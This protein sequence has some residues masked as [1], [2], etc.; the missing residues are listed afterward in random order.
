MNSWQIMMD[1]RALIV[2]VHGGSHES[3]VGSGR[4]LGEGPGGRGDGEGQLRSEIPRSLLRLREI[5]DEVWLNV[6]YCVSFD[7]RRE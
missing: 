2:V 7:T 6:V 3:R 5:D 1:G 4:A